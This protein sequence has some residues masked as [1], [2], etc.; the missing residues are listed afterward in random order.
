MHLVKSEPLTADEG[1]MDE[2]SLLRDGVAD[3]LNLFD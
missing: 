3:S 1:M 2:R